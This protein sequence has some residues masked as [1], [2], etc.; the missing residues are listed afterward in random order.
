MATILAIGIATLDLINEVASYPREDAEV[1]A[2]SHSVRRGGNATN[3]L[4]VL[5]QLG[6]SC[7]WAG[8][9]VDEP[10]AGILRADLD[11]YA[12]GTRYCRRVGQG[13]IPT[14]YITCSRATAS[15]TIVHYRDLPEFDFG[16]FLEIPLKTFDWVHFEGRNVAET[17]RMM[18][19]LRCQCPEVPVSLE[20]EKPR[21][22]IEAL[23]PYAN[24]LLFA[25]AFSDYCGFSP[26]AMLQ[27]TRESV[28]HADIVCTLSARGAVALS[29]SG[30]L[31][32]SAAYP[33][34]TL[35]DTIGAGDTF[36]AA[37]IDA[38][39]RGESLSASLQFAC[40]LAG[41]KCGQV[42][43]HGLGRTRITGDDD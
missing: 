16:S 6:H 22:G 35:V 14:S 20:V 29:S 13:K 28:P 36:N 15:R 21:E 1:R 19:R 33:P 42:G 8:V 11:R 34:A 9:W 27:T 26:E 41:A 40:R 32:S 31:L 24:L 5:S 39:L 30:E 25:K 10:D 38:A 17:L 3:T 43:F 4:V 37:M 7:E 12:I 23:F 18:E 2:L